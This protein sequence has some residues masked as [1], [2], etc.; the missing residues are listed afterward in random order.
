[1][2]AERV[3]PRGSTAFGH[4]P[5]MQPLQPAA[6]VPQKRD[7]QPQ[8]S[9]IAG[10]RGQ[11]RGRGGHTS[12]SRGRGRGRVG[13][14]RQQL[15]T[16]AISMRPVCV[17]AAIPESI[18]LSYGSTDGEDEGAIRHCEGAISSPVPVQVW[19]QLASALL[20]STV[21]G[22]AAADYD[23]GAGGLAA[24]AQQ[25]TRLRLALHTTAA[26]VRRTDSSSGSAGHQALPLLLQLC[27]CGSSLM[28]A[29]CR[30]SAAGTTSAAVISTGA[31]GSSSSSSGLL[32]DHGL[33]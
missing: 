3:S 12:S 6:Y 11:G 4:V 25:L 24:A 16:T 22:A 10:R 9:R 26:V 1:M 30:P 13:R 28:A 19:V 20:Q 23:A 29:A 5:A 14:G 18:D 7:V 27:T 33:A 8:H 32:D 2:L 15:P 17:P 31:P 21:Q